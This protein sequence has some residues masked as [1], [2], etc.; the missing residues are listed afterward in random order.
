MIFDKSEFKN[1]SYYKLLYL[2][3]LYKSA[4]AYNIKA[5]ELNK[6]ET[7]KIKYELNN[8]EL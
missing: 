8:L 1:N 2:Y 7:T 3:N 5:E 4:K 6:L